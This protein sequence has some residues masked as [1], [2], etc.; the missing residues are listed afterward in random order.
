MAT[1]TSRPDTARSFLQRG[2]DTAAEVSGAIADKLSAA[3]DPRAKLLRKR[4]WALRLGVFFT[5]ATGFWVAVTA[6]LASWSTPVWVLIIT[7][8][9]AAGAAFP[10]TL[11]WLRYRWL[12]AMPLPAE[13]PVSGRRLPPWGSAAR[14]PMSALLASERG[15]FSLLGVIE[16]GRMLP[17]DELHSL[18]AVA[19]Q[20]AHTMMATAHEIVS[21]EQAAGNAPDSRSHLLPTIN[22]FAA[23]LQQGAR[24]YNDMVTAAAQLV[25]A[26]NSGPVAAA[27]PAQQRYR[28]ELTDATDR[29]MGWAQAFDELGQL[30]R[31]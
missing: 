21:M 24:Q 30:R 3:S 23:Q 26:V 1:K 15:M 11:L 8:A 19:N 22:A 4:R 12:K 13:R 2:I 31:A 18:T 9:V 28:S 6:V 7:G 29:L 16:R 27:R 10:A 17:P 5:V 14:Q 20:S 25:S